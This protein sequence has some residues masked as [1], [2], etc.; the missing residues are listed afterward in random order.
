MFKNLTK[1]VIGVVTS[2]VDVAA[3]LITL[4][5]ALTDKK[6]PYTVTKAKN[7]KDN[8]DKAIDPDE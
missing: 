1:A 2:P 4:G 5:G 3:D 8:I 6:E 7:I